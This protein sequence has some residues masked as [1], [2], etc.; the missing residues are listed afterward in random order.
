MSTTG[1]NITAATYPTITHPQV[2]GSSY[3]PANPTAGS[4]TWTYSL[5]QV[6][7]ESNSDGFPS[8]NNATNSNIV[9]HKDINSLK[10]AIYSLWNI[11]NAAT[12]DGYTNRS[13]TITDN[14][15]FADTVTDGILLQ[16]QWGKVRQ[17]L[18]QFAADGKFTYRALDN[19]SS[20]D[21]LTASFYNDL[22]AAYNDYKDNCIC[23]SDCICNANCTCNAH[24]SCNY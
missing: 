6:H 17:T 2:G 24:C 7:V 11:N 9:D 1:N 5:C 14:P 18:A 20:G 22:V 23:N 16:S 19:I 8:L 10:Y 12:W 4:S 15:T 21:E 3:P 13:R